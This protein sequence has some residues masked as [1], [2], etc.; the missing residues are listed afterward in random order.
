[1]LLL[2]FYSVWL[3]RR[4]SICVGARRFGFQDQSRI[5]G[6]CREI[7]RA[8]ILELTLCADCRSKKSR[9]LKSSSDKIIALHTAICTINERAV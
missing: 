8:G 5:A 9:E 4:D 6:T 3:A 2:F 7:R 1:M